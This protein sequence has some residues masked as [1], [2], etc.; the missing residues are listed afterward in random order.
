MPSRISS[1]HHPTAENRNTIASVPL[2]NRVTQWFFPNSPPPPKQVSLAGED[3]FAWERT[4]T[5]SGST[6][7]STVT[8]TIT[9]GVQTRKHKAS[10]S[11]TFTSDTTPRA[12]IHVPSRSGDK[13]FEA[14]FSHPTIP[15]GR[16]QHYPYA[17]Y[18]GESLRYDGSTVGLAF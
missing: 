17:P 1:L 10:I 16:P 3:G 5:M 15:E 11:S 6:V 7:A 4:R 14:M 2:P 18:K 12:S 13:D 8:T 9:G